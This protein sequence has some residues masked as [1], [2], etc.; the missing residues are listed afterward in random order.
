MGVY[1]LQK[2]FFGG[3]CLIYVAE[4]NPSSALTVRAELKDIKDLKLIQR[5][6]VSFQFFD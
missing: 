5:N 6:T 3:G 2:L 1:V 4:L